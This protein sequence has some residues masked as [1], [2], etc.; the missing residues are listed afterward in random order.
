MARES[1]ADALR[2]L[3]ARLPQVVKEHEVLRVAATVEGRDRAK[4][5]E[6]VR[7]EILVWAQNR[8]GGR[9]PSAAWEHRDFE[10]LSG[11]RNSAAV[12]LVGNSVDLWAIRAEDPD[13]EVPGRIWTTEVVVGLQG[14]QPAR[15][16][17][18]L[19]A[20]TREDEIDIEPHTPGFVLQVVERCGLAIDGLELS[21]RPWI[22]NDSDEAERLID[23]LVDPGRRL[24]FLVL[25]VPETSDGPLL[26]PVVL[27]RATIGT[28]QVVV[29]SPEVAWTLTDRFGKQRSVFGGAV[30]AYMAGFSPEANPYAHRLSLPDSIATGVGTAQTLRWMRWLAASESVRAVRMGKDILAYATVRAAS[31]KLRQGQLRSEGASA[32]DQLEAAD[33]QIENLEKALEEAQ[34]TQDYFDQ[35]HR[36]AEER[37][38][39]AEEQLRAASFRI[40]QLTDQ[41]KQRGDD[42][43][44]AMTMPESW[45]DFANWCDVNLAGRVVLSPRARDAVK[46]PEFEDIVQAARCLLWLANQGRTRR[47]DGGGSVADEAVEEGIRNSHCGGDAYDFT[48]QGQRYTVDWHIKNGGNTR[49]PKRCLRIYYFWDPEAQRFVV[50]D[51][52]A[53]R[54]TSAT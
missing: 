7:R 40:A 28:A 24:P 21:P 32:A 42:P 25:S 47:L 48:W 37:A 52:P 43:D 12:R 51:M 30:R 38:I 54:R 35:E 33:A 26:D 45:S 18:R 31:L 41:L 9:L 17:A 11:G 50:A 44:R 3:A 23:M 39:A 22:V 15:F 49:S 34:A 4:A 16:S 2:P 46:T 19:L 5:A 27:T 53:H 13:K 20:S 14:E 29:V 6:D 1:I 36:R 8:S 10:Y